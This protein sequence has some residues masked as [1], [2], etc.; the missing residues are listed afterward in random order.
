MFADEVDHFRMLS[1]DGPSKCRILFENP[2][3]A[4]VIAY[5]EFAVNERMRCDFL[6]V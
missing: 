6:S 3:A 4:A 2:G 5:E 1:F